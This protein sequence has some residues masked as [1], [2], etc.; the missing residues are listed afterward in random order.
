MR[1]MVVLPLYGC[2]L[3]FDAA[4]LL[5]WVNKTGWSKVTGTVNRFSR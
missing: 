2:D 4:T 3:R 1:P 5:M